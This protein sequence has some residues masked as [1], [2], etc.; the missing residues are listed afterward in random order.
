GANDSILVPVRNFAA[1]KN[2]FRRFVSNYVNGEGQTQVFSAVAGGSFRL[3]DRVRADLGVR[4]EN[5]NY[6][7][8]SQNT[9]TTPVGGDT[10]NSLTLFDQDVWGTPSSY[11]HFSRSIGD[12][13]ASVGLNYSLTS[14]T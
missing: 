4:Y 5:D 13:A 3:S 10:L 6:V 14:Q 11:R 8:T 1:T 9:T 7:Q 12:W 2:G